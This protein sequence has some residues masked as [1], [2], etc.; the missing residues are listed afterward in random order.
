MS[1]SPPSTPSSTRS[2]DIIISRL[3]TPEGLRK[4]FP[5]N[6]RSRYAL[7]GTIVA[8]LG[9]LAEIRRRTEKNEEVKRRTPH[10]R[11]SAVH[12]YDGIK[13]WFPSLRLGSYE[14]FVPYKDTHKRVIINPIRPV[15]FD[16]HKRLFLDKRGEAAAPIEGKVG[17]NLR[18]LR[19]FS[20]MWAIIVFTP[21]RPQN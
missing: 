7:I 4:L 12:L 19:Q 2:L 10:R 15:I 11:N 21:T 17:L 3:L 13:L 1:P 5:K 8:L 6:P 20:A 14:I 18:F 16:A 9:T